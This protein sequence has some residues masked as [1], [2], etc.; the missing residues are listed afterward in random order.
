MSAVTPQPSSC[1]SKCGN[2]IV[3]NVPGPIGPAGA[4]GTNGTNG[5]NAYTTTTNSFVTVVQGFD[6]LVQVVDTSWMAED[7]V[8]WLKDPNSAAESFFRVSSIVSSTSVNLFVPGFT[9]DAGPGITFGAGTNVVVGGLQGPANSGT[10][11]INQG[12][13]GQTTATAAM[14]ALSP[15]TTKGDLIV[16]NGFN[17]PTANDVRLAVGSDG[18]TLHARSSQPTGLQWSAFDLSGTNSAITGAVPIANGGT[19]QTAKTAAFDALS[20]LTTAGDIIYRNGSNNIR[21]ALGTAGQ[22][23]RVNA[24]A[25]AP[26]WAANVNTVLQYQKTISPTKLNVTT[27]VPLDDTTPD[28]STDGTSIIALTLTPTNNTSRLAVKVLLNLSMHGTITDTLAAFLTVTGSTASVVTGANLV[29]EDCL[30]QIQLE[31]V[32]VP[33][34][35]S[36]ITLTV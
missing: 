10:L 3:S 21:L 19:G 5:A 4:A 29:A 11:Q 16:D 7:Q 15:T 2:E 17:S 28:S 1:C 8:L 24:G 12:G 36:P 20:P 35:T 26:E 13:T 23:L 32:F 33:G 22:Q 14:N 27:T 6:V 25:T 9:G 18:R 34:V 31:Y 30:T